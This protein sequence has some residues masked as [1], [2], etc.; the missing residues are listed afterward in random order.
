MFPSTNGLPSPLATL[1]E[2]FDKGDTSEK[3][4]K[5][6]IGHNLG[7]RTFLMLMPMLE[8]FGMS[9]VANDPGRD[10]DTVAQRRLDPV[11]ANKLAIYILKGL[12][13]AAISRRDIQQKPP[14]PALSEMQE[15]LGR[16]PYMALQPIVVNI[17]ECNPKG[18]DI[19]GFRLEDKRTDET[20]AFKVFI[21]QRHVFWVIDGQH[22]RRAME[23]VFAFL[24]YVRTSKQYPKKGN[25]LASIFDGQTILQDDLAVWE[26]CFD[27]ARSYCTLMLEVHLGLQTD[28]ERQLF[29]DL[30]RLGKKVDPSLALHFDN[31]NPINQ[32][33]KEEL[34]DNL[35]IGVT[36]TDN[37]KDLA[38]DDGRL[39]RKDLVAVNA[40]LLLNKGNIT[41]ATPAMLEGKQKTAI[42]F[43]SKVKEIPGFGEEQARMKTVAAQSVVLKAL[44]KL[45]YDF[46]F[47]NRRPDDGDDL[48]E[49]LLERM[50]EVDFSHDNLLWHYYELDASERHAHGLDTLHEYLPPEARANK[51]L[52]SFQSGFM[53]FSAK[54]NDIMPIIGDMI[55]WRLGLPARKGAEANATELFAAE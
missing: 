15:R 29:H 40:V 21:S 30:N 11:H 28:E 27:V 8:F 6:F 3:P 18:N 5:V 33:I 9:A 48:A 47:S 2:V 45:I 26:E 37:V 41:G 13:S 50:Q 22:R 42:R 20:A 51:D 7:H 38:N 24:E 35:G 44:A 32:F 31:S 25:S 14:L 23:L 4:M 17:R 54:H 55:R 34:V 39:L 16:Q 19:R 12:I 53:R 43:W 46:K 49:Q 36:E 52:G 1:D 10:G